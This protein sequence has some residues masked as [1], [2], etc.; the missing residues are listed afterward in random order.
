MNKEG[1]MGK[2]KKSVNKISAKTIKEKIIFI[3]I[4]VTGIPI[5]LLGMISYA[6][7]L[8]TSN[9]EFEKSTMNLSKSVEGNIDMKIKNVED[10]LE[11]LISDNT[12]NDNEKLMNDYRLLVE[13]NKEFENIFYYN[14]D[15]KNLVMYPDAGISVDEIDI[16]QRDWYVNAVNKKGEF[17]VSDVYIDI[18][19][20]S[21]IVT[22][23]KAVIVD[24][25]LLGVIG[26]DVNI[27][28]IIKSIE[29][30]DLG[31]NALVSL[32]D[33]SGVVIA[34]TNE[35][36]IGDKELLDAN[37][38]NE[39]LENQHGFVDVVEDKSEYRASYNTSELT[40]WK[41]ILQI[42]EEELN[43]TAHTFIKVILGTIVLVVLCVLFI[44]TKFARSLGKCIG[45][46]KEGSIR[47]ASGD[48]SKNIDINSND[49]LED[50]ANSFNEMQANI[51][52]LI[53]NVNNSIND[54]NDT[55]I[56]L[57]GM[58]DDVA[59]AM[60]EVAATV[61]EISKGCVESAFSIESL[62]G[63]LDKVS[64]QINVINSATSNIN[65][66]VLK[67]NDMGKK[68][69]E[70]IEDLMQ[71]SVET[72]NS[73]IEVSEVI[74]VV[75]ESVKN[76]GEMN[77]TIGR[78]TEQTNLLAL[79]AAIEAARAGEAGN[80]FAVVA[81]EIRKLAEET[82]H[83]AKEINTIV[84]EVS[85]KVNKAV[86]TADDTMKVVKSQEQSI[87]G[88]QE[89]FETI[90]TSVDGLTSRVNEISI[91]LAEVGGEKNKVV[92]ELQ[93]IS[94]IG[95]ETAAGTE[96]VSASCYEIAASTDELAEHSNKLK[97]LSKNLNGEIKNFKF[98]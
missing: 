1:Q 18:L 30:I 69:V 29:N 11:F 87:L 61:D 75:E 24:G 76:I 35:S 79:N 3:M 97:E 21:E 55:S 16:S 17:Y 96:E 46:I 45:K 33:K 12:F 34:H 91:G 19:T 26:I 13:S 88:A 60:A 82:S 57:A 84:A 51:S 10:T 70:V 27:G 54:V 93:S 68:G 22:L 98:K 74:S 95:E 65:S 15:V 73:T 41:L 6:Q 85:Q 5:A 66:I 92:L 42:P 72:R 63:N 9:I 62:S 28:D 80:G 94:S 23:S 67:T 40:G 50:L 32:L 71:K 58:S 2:D 90:I 7:F 31:E 64:N 56:N 59:S 8:K 77:K 37:V 52:K 78:I 49:E 53:N 47:A 20:S 39:I 36:N 44:G 89:I 38:M 86:N 4:I 81:D 25:Q 48:F 83:S 14:H 43:S